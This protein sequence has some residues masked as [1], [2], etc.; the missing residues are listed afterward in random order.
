MPQKA[1]IQ[2]AETG[3]GQIVDLLPGGG[4]WDGAVL[5]SNML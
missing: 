5:L 3:P 1:P 2:S 4:C